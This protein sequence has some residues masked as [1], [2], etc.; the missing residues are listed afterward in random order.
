MALFH[1]NL[2]TGNVME[3]PTVR[4]C[5][6]GLSPADHYMTK[7]DADSA[8]EAALSITHASARLIPTDPEFDRALGRAVEGGFVRASKDLP[9][10]YEAQLEL[11]FTPTAIK[12]LADELCIA[13]G[14]SKKERIAR[15]LAWIVREFSLAEQ[16]DERSA[17]SAHVEGFVRTR[18]AR[19]RVLAA[20][21]SSQFSSE[22]ALN[23]A[24]SMWMYRHSRFHQLAKTLL[25]ET[26]HLV[27]GYSRK[28]ERA[29]IELDNSKTLEKLSID[30]DSLPDDA[31][32]FD[33]ETDTENGFGLR[34]TRTQ[35]TELVVS[36][37]F[38]SW[39]FSGDEQYILE[40]FAELLNSQER[41]VALVGWNNRCFDNIALQTRAEYH[42]TPGWNCV[43]Y[44]AEN[45]SVFEPAGP[46]YDAQS[47]R[48]V[49]P[50]GIILE[51]IDV[52]Q[53]K[54]ALD[55]ERG[56]RYSP[57]LKRF[58]ESLGVRPVKVDRQ[59]LHEMSD[60]DRQDYVLS[61][62]LSTLAAWGAVRE[63]TLS[64]V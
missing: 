55:R 2:A 21:R 18:D 43:L 58:V 16:V 30:V 44:P 25:F 51:D 11:L 60:S 45:L 52:F 1:L 41:N 24:S 46:T 50:G 6:M 26:P 57:G 8:R 62:G 37:R 27:T 12:H 20:L 59:K 61:D 47:L 32:A 10:N 4:E 23:L 14:S 54:V 53:E 29:S 35:I 42:E 28:R 7:E 64:R 5:K 63:E 38:T 31:L 40:Q 39:V 9:E 33:V 17:Y 15:A 36:S 19:E 13:S 3:C 56:E 34:P 49:T 22:D 48:W